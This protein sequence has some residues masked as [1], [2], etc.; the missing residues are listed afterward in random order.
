VTVPFVRTTKPM[1]SP[2][3]ASAATCAVTGR[4]TAPPG[5]SAIVAGAEMFA[6]VVAVCG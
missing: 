3:A 5:A 6:P 1:S 2:V 4:S